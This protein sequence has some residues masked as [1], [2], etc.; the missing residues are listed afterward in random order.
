MPGETLRYQK[1]DHVL[2]IDL[3]S[4]LDRPLGISRMLADLRELYD[5]VALDEEVYV[6][7]INDTGEK[8]F[9]GREGGIFS[10][11]EHPLRGGRASP[12]ALRLHSLT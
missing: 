1:K 12:L 11:G 8:A 4:S 10:D 7:V 2:V 5:E 9:L 6:V 3:N